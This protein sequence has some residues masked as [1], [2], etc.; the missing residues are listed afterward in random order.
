MKT[1]IEVRRKGKWVPARP[2]DVMRLRLARLRWITNWVR[3]LINT[4][5]IGIRFDGMGASP[6]DIID[7]NVRWRGPGVRGECL[8]L[9]RLAAAH[10]RRLGE[11]IRLADDDEWGKALGKLASKAKARKR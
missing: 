6:T 5:T 1:R 8:K 11:G 9:A 2:K 10:L 3:L 7:G 4:S